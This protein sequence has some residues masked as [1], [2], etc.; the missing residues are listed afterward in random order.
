MKSWATDAMNTPRAFLD[1]P[2]IA[3]HAW[4]SLNKWGQLRVPKW[5]IWRNLQELLMVVGLIFVALPIGA[6]EVSP[7]VACPAGNLI[8]G[9]MPIEDT[10]IDGDLVRLTDDAVANEGAFWDSFPAVV[11]V[12][13]AGSVTYDLGGP[14]RLQVAYLQ[15]DANDRYTIFT[16]LD[17]V[18]F[19]R[20]ID[21]TT[22]EGHGLRGRAATLRGTVARYVRIG[23]ALGDSFFS[24]SEFQIFCQL[25]DPFP[26]KFKVLQVPVEPVADSD[27]FEWNNITSARFEL[28]LALLGLALLI[29]GAW[30]TRKGRSNEHKKLRDGLLALL[31]IIAGAAYINLGA[32]HFSS[33]IHDWDTF[34][35]YIGSKYFRELEYDRLYECTAIADWEAGF[36][37]RV[38]LRKMMNLRTNEMELT[39]EILRHPERCKSHF[40]EERWASFQNDITWFRDRMTAKRWEDLQT[41]HGFN[42]TPVWTIAGTILSNTGPASDTQI[43]ILDAIDCFLMLGMVGFIWWAF[44]WRVLCIALLV[45]STNFPNRWYW[46]GGSLLRYDWLLWTV[47]A[48]CL[49]RKERYF[50]SGAAIGYA[51]LLRIF[52]GFLMLGP[53]VAMVLQLFRKRRID[54][55]YLAMIGGIVL[56]VVMLVPISFLTANSPQIYERFV[57]N[58]IKHRNTPLTNYMGLPTL[59]AWRP[60]EMGRYLRSDA[61]VDPWSTWKQA[62][63]DAAQEFK[64]LFLL[65]VATA[66]VLLARAVHD[67]E[68]WFALALGATMIGV[69]VELTC[70]YY[71]FLIVIALLTERHRNVG[72]VLLGVTFL[73]QVIA[74]VGVFG[75]LNWSDEQYTAM[76]AVTMMGLVMLLYWFGFKPKS[77]VES[78]D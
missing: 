50:L 52:P 2:R 36:E 71:A 5:N 4:R 19:Q 1:T 47:A 70:Y 59:I 75:I 57:E 64:W 78:A 39:T 68:P 55:R 22:V 23:E 18:S 46:T 28:V 76:S 72:I 45:Y 13:S 49:A 73:T 6:E 63:R 41:D 60:T 20:L 16:S 26:P 58:T 10:D 38:E 9:R 32:F 48:V 14:T 67:R 31:G 66:L 35:Y 29:W 44:G 40:S 62:R 15:A 53:A 21:F 42:G 43:V 33:F 30:L 54:R 12:T 24:M 11:L 56:S 3:N 34:H 17:G 77:V 37:R 27:Y 65:T 74:A 69:S 25:P 8:A 51:I 7:A 61:L